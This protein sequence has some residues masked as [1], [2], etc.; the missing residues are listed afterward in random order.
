[1]PTTERRADRAN[2]AARG[3]T[4]SIA[5]ELRN[6]RLAAGLSQASVAAFAG[7]S[8]AEVSRIER[9]AAPWMSVGLLYRVAAAVGL[10]PSIRL[11]ATPNP[12]RDA[13]QL[14]L[15]SRLRGRLATSLEWQT[16]VPLPGFGDQRGWDAVI[17]GPSW[18][19]AV[20]AETRL[21][22]IQALTRRIELKRR[23]AR[24][25]R[26]ILLVAD[27]R[28][29]ALALET[30]RTSLAELFPTPSRQLLRALGAGIEPSGS[31]IVLL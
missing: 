30:A 11:Y 4:A 14:A 18:Q 10:E 25:A 19:I 5:A 27:T 20:E 17:G 16:E 29:N 3:A 26:V 2:R 15:L 8:A 31:G 22:D 23:D 12:L 1:V 28:A 13:P 24:M 9:L 21:R 7:V 6:A